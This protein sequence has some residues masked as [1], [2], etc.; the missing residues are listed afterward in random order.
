M[1]FFRESVWLA[2]AMACVSCRTGPAPQPVIA[3]P[4]ESAAPPLATTS[5]SPPATGSDSVAPPPEPSVPKRECLRHEFLA[6]ARWSYVGDELEAPDAALAVGLGHRHPDPV[7]EKLCDTLHQR[8]QPGIPE[9]AAA[10]CRVRFGPERQGVWAVI[11][12]TPMPNEEVLSWRLVYL[13][14]SGRAT[15]SPKAQG[16]GPSISAITDFNGDG[17][18]EVIT[19]VVFSTD[20]SGGSRNEYTIWTIERGVIRPYRPAKGLRIVWLKDQDQDGIPELVLDPYAISVGGSHGWAEG[21]GD[22]SIL[23]HADASGRFETTGPVPRA[24]AREL[25]PEPPRVDRLFADQSEC[26]AKDAHCARLWGIAEA[27]IDAAL[28]R[29]C[30]GRPDDR[31][32][33]HS[34]AGWQTISGTEPPFVLTDP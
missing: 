5:G 12:D 21:L 29:A 24:Y 18:P 20:V 27:E 13:D 15:K 16:R 26:Y 3:A 17:Q 33:E 34:I 30:E 7:L 28:E 19:R 1:K 22:W 9:D 8:F 2:S 6:A 25:C 23:A 31:L 11:E 14:A 4:V 10:E 32:C